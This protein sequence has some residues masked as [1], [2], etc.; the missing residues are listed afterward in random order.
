MKKLLTL[1]M[2]A[3]CALPSLAF[4]AYND[5]TL[6]TSA[7]ISVGGYTLSVSGSSATIQSIVVNSNNFSVTLASG[8]SF[9]VAS[10]SL[11]QLSSD[12]AS[13]VTSN[14][15][16][17]SASS[18]SLAYSGGGT[19]TNVITPSS[20]ICST[21]SSSGGNSG[22]G[23]NG[24]IVGSLGSGGTIYVAPSTPVPTTTVSQQPVQPLASTTV[25]VLSAPSFKRDLYIGLTGS[26]VKA[27]QIYLNAHGFVLAPSGLGSPGHETTTFGRATRGAVIRLQKAV[28]IKP[29]AGYFGLKTRAYVATHS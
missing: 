18:I 17:G 26:D 27:L 8:S 21:A 10:P 15:C 1:A 13:D 11:N 23:G 2:I 24:P 20:T 12:V 16:T 29:T 19:V 6:T 4:A 14:T 22:G 25:N 7:V 28:G 5:V 3:A 9:T